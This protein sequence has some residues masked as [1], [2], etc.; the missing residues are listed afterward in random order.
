MQEK[1]E[2]EEIRLKSLNVYDPDWLIDKLDRYRHW[3][4]LSD[5]LDWVVNLKEN[6]LWKCENFEDTFL[7]YCNWTSAIVNSNFLIK[8]NVIFTML[9]IF[10]K[11]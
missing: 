9:E 3:K 10:L 8:Y 11:N 1:V 5:L 2:H 7:R 6:L 4:I